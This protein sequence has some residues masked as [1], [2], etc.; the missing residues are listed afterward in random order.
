MEVLIGKG[1][2]GSSA[3][4]ARLH[5]KEV[6][7]LV[8]VSGAIL[9]NY[10]FSFVRRAYRICT[11]TLARAKPHRQ[12]HLTTGSSVRTLFECI[13]RDVAPN[14]V[15]FELRGHAAEQ[16]SVFVGMCDAHRL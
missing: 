13:S 1:R 10:L 8:R 15:R 12:A 5:P 9:R 11:R 6:V 16:T 7:C 2:G 14:F 3:L 4:V